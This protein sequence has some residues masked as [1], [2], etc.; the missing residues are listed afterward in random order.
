MAETFKGQRT[1]IVNSSRGV[2][3]T[4]QTVSVASAPWPA[5]G[6]LGSL[7]GQLQELRSRVKADVATE[8]HRYYRYFVHEF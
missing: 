4:A 1:H 3:I 5:L 7:V 2:E 6:G 8:I